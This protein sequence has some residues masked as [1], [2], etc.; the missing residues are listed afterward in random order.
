MQSDPAKTGPKRHNTPGANP[1][2]VH[3]C[4]F[5]PIDPMCPAWSAQKM[6]RLGVHLAKFVWSW[7]QPCCTLDSPP[8]LSPLSLPKAQS[9]HLWSPH[10]IPQQRARLD[11]L[12]SVPIVCQAQCL[13]LRYSSEPDEEPCACN[14]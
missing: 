8:V 2:Q 4:D 1:V 3:Q 10:S 5:Q 13:A 12:Y 7:S 14:A 11:H 9:L 6:Q